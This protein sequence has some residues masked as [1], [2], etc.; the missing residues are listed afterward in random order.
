VPPYFLCW[1]F[2]SLFV[3]WLPFA[4][5]DPKEDIGQTDKMTARPNQ[6]NIKWV[7]V[8]RILPSAP[9]AAAGPTLTLS[10]DL[11]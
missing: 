3:F 9:V 2:W 1:V 10:L 5:L 6:R 8:R 11:R 7:E 4:S